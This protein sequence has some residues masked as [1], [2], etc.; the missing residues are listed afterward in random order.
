MITQIQ[1]QLASYLLGVHYVAH[2]T[3]LTILVLRKLSLVMHIESM[4]ES[5]YGFFLHSPKKALPKHWRQKV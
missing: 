4:L 5:L 2:Q 3:N 1:K